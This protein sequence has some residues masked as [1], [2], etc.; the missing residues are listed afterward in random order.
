MNCYDVIVIGGGVNGTGTARDCA[1][2]G[3]KTLLVEKNDFGSGTSGASTSMI[4]GGLR[5]L[6]TDV[7]TTKTSCLDSGYTQKIAPHLLWRIPFLM[8]VFGSGL[9]AKIYTELVET[10]LEAY[11]HFSVPLKNGRSHT[12][13]DPNEVYRLEP[14][15]AGGIHAA[16]TFDEWGIYAHRLC[17]VNAL[18]AVENG[19]EALNH[20]EVMGLEWGSAEG[21]T[22]KLK[23]RLQNT[24]SKVLAKVVVNATGPWSPQVA[25]LAK[26]EVKL[27]P[28][29]G[30][31]LVSDRRVSNIAIVATAVDGRQI[32]VLPFGNCSMIGTTDDDYYGDLDLLVAHEDEVE[33]L[34]QGIEKVFPTIRQYRWTHTTVGVRPTLFEWGKNEDDLYR[35]HAIFDH[36]SEGAPGLFSIAGGKLAS[37]RWM[38]EEM[39]DVVAKKFENKNRCR[40][41]IDPLPGAEAEV[42]LNVV[43]RKY[44]LPLFTVL[45]LYH[46][47]GCRIEEILKETESHPSW[48]RVVC[49]CE[50]V[51]EAE[52]R[53][54]IRKEWA[55]NLSDIARRT[56]LGLGSCQG[57]DCAVPAAAILADELSLTAREIGAALQAFFEE[58]WRSKAPV[59]RGRELA[60]EEITRHLLGQLEGELQRC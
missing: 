43:S 9:Q 49:V 48:K 21:I 10:Y 47:H 23:D 22:V 8:P 15:L 33:Y 38:S 45:K 4:H 42:D 59:L 37:Y 41:H 35:E 40:T 2:R 12:R 32:F 19:A 30:I 24:T 1:T 18:S 13:L 3:L 11:D 52:V 57:I 6:R 44:Q 55:R 28:G 5:Y 26:A 46:R 20:T 36:S 14:G 25:A 17:A 50:P 31:H 7:K 58:R 53:Y 56:R 54:V 34:L 39:A 51:L 60:Q 29:K 27:R 16:L